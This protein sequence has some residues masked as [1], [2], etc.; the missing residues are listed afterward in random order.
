MFSSELAAAA[1]L[2]VPKNMSSSTLQLPWSSWGLLTVRSLLLEV[3]SCLDRDCPG[4][5]NCNAV[6]P[7][8]VKASLPMLTASHLGKAE[9][10]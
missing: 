8:K 7:L 3:A 2:R 1:S 10:P 9:V 4:L 6:A 5:S